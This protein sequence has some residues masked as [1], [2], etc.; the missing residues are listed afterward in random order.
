MFYKQHSLPVSLTGYA[1]L[2]P[3]EFVFTKKS[4]ASAGG[5]VGMYNAQR[6]AI[7]PLVHY[8]NKK[9][10]INAMYREQ[11]FLMDAL[12]NP[13]IDIVF[14]FGIAGCGKTFLAVDAGFEQCIQ[15]TVDSGEN[16]ESRKAIY[17]KLLITRPI[18]PH[19]G[20]HEVGYLPGTLE[21]KVAP[22]V[23]PIHDQCDILFHMYAIQRLDAEELYKQN[24]LEVQLLSTMRGRN[25]PNMFWIVDEGQNFSYDSYETIMTRGADGLKLVITGD[26]SPSQTDLK[27]SHGNPL[28]FNNMLMRND[29]KTATVYFED[30]RCCVRG[31]IPRRYLE[32]KKQFESER[33][34]FRK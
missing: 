1:D 12:R 29:P 22:W 16:G 9:S 5:L 32:A 27:V 13:E 11:R 3:N 2:K 4:V 17:Q 23:A 8:E 21:E 15:P 7:V 30:E 19:K 18:I 6:E 10:P 24:L 34:D 26:P 31:D 33:Q 20:Q 25:Y 28:L 14:A